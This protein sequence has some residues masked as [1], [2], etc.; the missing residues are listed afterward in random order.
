MPQDNVLALLNDVARLLRLRGR[1]HTKTI[2]MPRAQWV[3]STWL[4][5]R[6]GISQNELAA[7]IVVEPFTV[8]RLVDRLELLGF[9][10]RKSDQSHRGVWRLHMTAAPQPVL[11]RS[12]STEIS[13][14]L[15]LPKASAMRIF[16]VWL[17]RLTE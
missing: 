10:E 5:R 2:G 15:L 9:V 6:P 11:E 14:S 7:L 4:D 8:A 1:Q 13:Q 3:I 12:N 16:H 17:W